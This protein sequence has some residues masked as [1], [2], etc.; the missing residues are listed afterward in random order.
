MATPAFGDWDDMDDMD[1]M[2]YGYPMLPYYQT[3]DDD[4]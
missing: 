4:D 2:D 1:D 3:D